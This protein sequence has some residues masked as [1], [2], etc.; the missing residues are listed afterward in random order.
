M[1]ACHD[2]TSTNTL[3][4]WVNH[5]AFPLVTVEWTEMVTMSLLV[6]LIWGW[7]QTMRFSLGHL[8]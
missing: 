8:D 6:T 1:L 5:L 7:V 2:H 4:S 3:L